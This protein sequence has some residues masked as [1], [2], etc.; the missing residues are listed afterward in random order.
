MS[1]PS[2]TCP[3]GFKGARVSVRD[4]D[5]G[6]DVHLVAYGDAQELRRRAH[7]AAEQYGAHAHKGLGHEG[8]HDDGEHHGLGL[9]RLG[10]EVVTSEE[11]TEDGALIHVDAVATADRAK[12]RDAL[13]ARVEDARSGDCP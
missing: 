8:K 9:A 7:D 1:S 10:I 5:A 11:D 12:L 6:A 3:L 13:R 4:T 2:T